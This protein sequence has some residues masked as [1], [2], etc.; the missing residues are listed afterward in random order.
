MIEKAYS[1]A[2]SLLKDE[3]RNPTQINDFNHSYILSYDLND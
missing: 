3:M 1:E 2:D